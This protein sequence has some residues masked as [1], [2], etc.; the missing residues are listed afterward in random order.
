MAAGPLPPPSVYMTDEHTRLCTMALFCAAQNVLYI[1]YIPH[2]NHN[3]QHHPPPPP[4]RSD[5]IRSK[6]VAGFRAMRNRG[7]VVT[8]LPQPESCLNPRGWIAHLPAAICI[9]SHLSFTCIPSEE[10]N[11]STRN[12]RHTQTHSPHSLSGRRCCQIYLAAAG[13]KLFHC[14]QDYCVPTLP[15]GDEIDL[16]V[17]TLGGVMICG[18]ECE[19]TVEGWR[20]VY[21]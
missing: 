21:L 19:G 18:L 16:G 20:G 6:I 3:N 15:G 4:P 7:L 8:L 12:A 2:Q 11:T 1:S 13:F 10:W 9:A 5:P 14:V 17:S